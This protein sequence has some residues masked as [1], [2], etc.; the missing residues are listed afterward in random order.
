MFF[1]WKSDWRFLLENI[2]IL[3]NEKK[4]VEVYTR[5]NS[6]K[7]LHDISFKYKM[8]NLA[9][10]TVLNLQNLPEH[11]SFFGKRVSNKYTMHHF[12]H[13]CVSKTFAR[14]MKRYTHLNVQ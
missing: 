1:E 12:A 2:E 13:E 14:Y 10:Y 8:P 5:K 4:S 9:N 7:F 3:C 11:Q 6:L